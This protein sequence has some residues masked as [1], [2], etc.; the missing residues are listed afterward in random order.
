MRVVVP[1]AV[2]AGEIISRMR[3]V[4]SAKNDAELAGVLGLG[5]NAPS[6]WRQR[7]SPPYAFCANLAQAHG[8]SMDWLV[9]GR[10]P[11]HLS[12]ATQPVIRR[13][14]DDSVGLSPAARRLTQFV[15]DWD[16]ARPEAE[17][18]WLEQHVKRTVPEYAEWL[19]DH[20][21]T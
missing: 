16:A 14:V 2:N 10:G 20:S 17:A 9:F 13:A 3:E 5:H 4:V 15:G 8:I 11:K 12:N 21:A 18:I 1:A 7:K 19:A 6:N